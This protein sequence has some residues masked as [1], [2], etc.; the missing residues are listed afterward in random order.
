MNETLNKIKTMDKQDLHK[1]VQDLYLNRT[2]YDD[3]DFSTLIRA[4]NKREYVLI[5][6]L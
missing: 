6:I 1:F 3:T 2:S 5:G 4:A